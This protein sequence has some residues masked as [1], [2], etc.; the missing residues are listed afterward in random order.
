MEKEQF[1]GKL[2]GF[3]DRE[4]M[5]GMEAWVQLTW[6]GYRFVLAHNPVWDNLIHFIWQHL[7]ELQPSETICFEFEDFP[8]LQFCLT[9]CE[10]ITWLFQQFCNESL[11]KNHLH[12]HVLPLLH[13]RIWNYLISLRVTRT[14]MKLLLKLK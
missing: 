10:L 3:F 7:I 4:R 12:M 2:A 9:A 5:G 6:V 13:R 14:L 1:S 8:V 11:I